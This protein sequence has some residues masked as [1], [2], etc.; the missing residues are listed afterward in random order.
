MQIDY[1]DPSNVPGLPDD[2]QCDVGPPAPSYGGWL[3]TYRSDTFPGV[4][5]AFV[6][7]GEDPYVTYQPPLGV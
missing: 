4:W 2:A 1:R 3:Y 5:S 7:E 6:H